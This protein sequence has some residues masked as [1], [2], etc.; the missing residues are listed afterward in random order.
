MLDFGQFRLRT[1]RRIGRS[2]NWPKS[3][4]AEVEQMVF[5]L[6]LLSL[7]FC[8]F[9]CIFLFFFFM[10]LFLLISL[11]TFFCERRENSTQ[12]RNSSTSPGALTERQRSGVDW[13][14]HPY[15]SAA[16]TRKQQRRVLQRTPTSLPTACG[17]PVQFCVAE[18]HSRS[19]RGRQT[20][21]SIDFTYSSHV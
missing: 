15:W 3:K 16:P 20:S 21:E 19:E 1:I 9:F 18:V 11:F 5:A 7:F 14:L 8:F 10:F 13:H 4:L 6:F 12:N 2:R 17:K